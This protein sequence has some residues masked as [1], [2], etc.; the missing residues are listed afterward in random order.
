MPTPDKALAVKLSSVA[1]ELREV[2]LLEDA[3]ALDEAAVRLLEYGA[4][5]HVEQIVLGAAEAYV[6]D[7]IEVEDASTWFKSA[8][9]RLKDFYAYL[10]ALDYEIG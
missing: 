4:Y 5:E 7:V 3:E 8:P 9:D 6:A 10:G 2:D 1:D